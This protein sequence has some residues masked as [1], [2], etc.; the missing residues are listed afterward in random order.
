LQIVRR[1]LPYL[2]VADAEVEDFAHDFRTR[3]DRKILALQ[4]TAPEDFEYEVCAKLLMSTD[5]FF[6]GADVNR[7]V[8]YVV[9]Y[10]P[11]NGCTSPFAR[12]M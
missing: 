2:R 11:Y 5:F 1:R 8:R 3:T 12:V 10:D 7:P 6:N 9:F 4:V